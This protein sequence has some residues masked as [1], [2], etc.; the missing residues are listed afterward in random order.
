MKWQVYPTMHSLR[1][2]QVGRLGGAP[3]YLEADGVF[4]GKGDFAGRHQVLLDGVPCVVE[5]LET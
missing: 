2:K 1:T 5:E 3:V 4:P